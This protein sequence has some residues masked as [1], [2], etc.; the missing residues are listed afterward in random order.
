MSNVAAASKLTSKKII[1]SDS[2]VTEPENAFDEIDP[3]FRDRR[4]EFIVHEGLGPCY[5]IPDLKMP[6]PMS[7]I[8]A[9]GRAPEDIQNFKLQWEDLEPLPN[10]TR[11]CQGTMGILRALSGQGN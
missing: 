9:A 8:N 6:V 11:P 4:P 3:K 2:H 7:M 10:P 5:V 1:S